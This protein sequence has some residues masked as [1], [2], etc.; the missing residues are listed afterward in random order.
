MPPKQQTILKPEYMNRFRCI[1]TSCGWNCCADGWRIFIDKAHYQVLRNC[2]DPELIELS[3][4]SLKRNKGAA[5]DEQYA[6]I[7]LDDTGRCSFQDENDRCRIQL[8]LGEK[9]LSH[10]CSVYPRTWAKIDGGIELS[11]NLSCPHAARLAI[12]DPEGMSFVR[13][14]FSVKTNLTLD[15]VPADTAGDLGPLR[16]FHTVREY[17]IG[18]L[19]NRAFSLDDRLILLGLL[20]KRFADALAENPGADLAA[21]QFD[22]EGQLA[23]GVNESQL[24]QMKPEP[25]LQARLTKELVDEQIMAQKGTPRYRELIGKS[26]SGIGAFTEST[27]QDVADGYAAAY[28]DYY[29]PFMREKEYLLENFLVNEYFRQRMPFGKFDK[30]WDSYAFL[31]VLYAVTRMHLTGLASFH[32]GLDD[33]TVAMLVSALCREIMHNQSFIGKLVELLKTSG[34][35]SLAHMVI[36]VKPPMAIHA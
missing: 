36:L 5:S 10:V 16:F 6:Q 2:R 20:N 33:E 32:K 19:Q 18:L 15:G 7:V 22:F 25:F 9:A 29:A 12:K 21:I 11:A 23:G 8:A 30:I 24:A 28:R 14:E 13:E 34:T 1:G 3:K 27:M 17:A 26:L 31:C 4:T 35:V